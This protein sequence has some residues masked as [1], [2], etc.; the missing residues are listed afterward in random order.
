MVEPCSGV[1]MGLDNISCTQYPP[2]LDFLAVMLFGGGD[3]L[4]PRDV[5]SPSLSP[6]DVTSHSPL[7]E[8]PCSATIF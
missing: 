7:Q 8:W 6:R 3:V 4:S 5:T 2:C 1:I